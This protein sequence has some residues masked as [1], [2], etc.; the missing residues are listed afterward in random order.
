ML[1]GKP[2]RGGEH[3]LNRELLYAMERARSRLAV[4]IALE[5]K[6]TPRER[7]QQYL[8]TADRV[9]RCVREIRGLHNRNPE[10][11][12]EWFEALSLLKQPLPTPDGDSQGEAQTM[13]RRMI[14]V[15]EI[16]EKNGGRKGLDP[17]H[18]S[19]AHE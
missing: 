14:E 7:W 5:N 16:L 2:A 6:A 18:A 11:H 12:L 3:R 13:C 8:E 17:R 10:R 4:A 19:E 15:L 9:R 1:G